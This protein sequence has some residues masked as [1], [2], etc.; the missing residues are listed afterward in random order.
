MANNVILSSLFLGNFADID[1]DE[2]ND[3]TESEASLLGTYGTAATPLSQSV[4]P[5]VSDSSDNFLFEDNISTADDWTYDTGSG[6]QVT[7]L[8]SIVFYYGDV[9]YTDGSSVSNVSFNV[10][11]MVNGD[12]FLLIGDS[13]SYLSNKP[14]E[15][16]SMNSVN[17]DDIGGIFQDRYDGNAFVCFASDTRIDTPDGPRAVQTLRAGELVTTLDHGAQPVA[18]IG[19]RRLTFPAAPEAQKPFQL[20]AGCFAVGIPTRDL[21][22]SPQHRLLGVT[23]EAERLASV[24]SFAGLPGVRQMTGKRAVIYYTLM[25]PRHEIIFANGLAVESFYPGPYSIGVLSPLQRLQVIASMPH[26][27]AGQDGFYGPHA[28]KPLKHKAAMHL[29]NK[30]KLNICRYQIQRRRRAWS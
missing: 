29:L 26:F 8:D 20:K 19:G 14:I 28:R 17:N 7:D 5:I 1:T 13:H 6:T 27:D 24:K 25:L 4:V 9:T 30:G 12:T 11:Q 2:T 18:W 21:I 3:V 22:V 23:P 15:S 10:V 16:I